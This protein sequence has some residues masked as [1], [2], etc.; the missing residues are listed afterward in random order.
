MLGV[1]LGIFLAYIYVMV[2][3]R[4]YYYVLLY[5]KGGISK[6]QLYDKSLKLPVKR[7]DHYLKEY[8][9]PFR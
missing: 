5:K 7:V 9:D 8:T 2:E 3:V 6:T 1:Y 4:P